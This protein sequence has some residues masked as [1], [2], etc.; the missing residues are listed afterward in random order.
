MLQLDFGA[1]CIASTS[2]P[3]AATFLAPQSKPYVLSDKEPEHNAANTEVLI[4]GAA[5]RAQNNHL[6]ALHL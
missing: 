4:A 3:S 5:K 6:S 1:G 2:E